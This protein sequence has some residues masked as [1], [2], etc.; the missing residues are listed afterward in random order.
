MILWPDVAAH[1]IKTADYFECF[2]EVKL[3]PPVL[4]REES[5]LLEPP[6]IGWALEPRNHS[7]RPLLDPLNGLYICCGPRGPRRHSKF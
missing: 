3:F 6:L 2:D 4:E 5:E 7:D 1:I